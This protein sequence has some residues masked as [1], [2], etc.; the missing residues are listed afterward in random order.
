MPELKTPDEWCQLLGFRVM[1]PD[2]WRNGASLGP[3]PWSDPIAKS[4]FLERLMPCTLL[5]LRR[6][7]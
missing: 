4:E 6:T 5:D 2:G 1:D 7:P 3:R